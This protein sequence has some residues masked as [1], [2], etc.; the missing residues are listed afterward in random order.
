MT[1][2]ATGPYLEVEKGE[3]R[4]TRQCHLGRLEWPVEIC[5]GTST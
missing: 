2:S 3:C 5:C 1:V 4:P